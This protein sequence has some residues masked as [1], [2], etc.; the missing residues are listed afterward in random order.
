MWILHGK[1]GK[2]LLGPEDQ[3]GRR[4][5]AMNVMGSWG[6]RGQKTNSITFSILPNLNF[7][8]KE[9]DTE[10]EFGDIHT[11]VSRFRNAYMASFLFLFWNIC[12]F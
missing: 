10:R 12:L 7:T 3:V 2:E 1:R 5:D 8:E 6:Q 4:E 9:T 11:V